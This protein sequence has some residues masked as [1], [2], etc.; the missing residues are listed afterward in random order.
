MKFAV[1]A[2]LVVCPA[3]AHWPAQFPNVALSVP[4]LGCSKPATMLEILPALPDPQA[5]RR[6]TQALICMA[7][8]KH[9]VPAAF[10]KS[11]VAAESNF[12]C[13]ALSPK[14]AVGLMQLMPETAREYGAD[15]SIP[16]QNVDAGTHYLRVLMDKYRKHGDSLQ[17][18]IA[19]YNAGPAMVDRYHGVPPFRETRRYVAR[20]L[21]FLHR[22]Q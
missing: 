15:P 6:D 12:D 4:A 1:S 18:V 9:G 16:E 17:R 14:G 7:A 22:F 3:F 19:A 21:G 13:D 5:G 8:E 11:I 2:L 10:V 20:V